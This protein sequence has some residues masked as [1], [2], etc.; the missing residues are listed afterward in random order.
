MTFSKIRGGRATT[1]ETWDGVRSGAGDGRPFRLIFLSLCLVM[2]IGIAAGPAFAATY[3]VNNSGSPVCH[4][5][6]TAGSQTNPFCTPDYG[7]TRIASGDTLYVRS[8]TYNIAN[9]FWGITGPSGTASA[10][11]HISVYPGDTVTLVGQGVDTGRIK[12]SNVS[13][14]TFDGFKVTN[15]NQGLFAETIN[16]VTISF[17]E[18]YNVGQEAIHI[19]FNSSFVT[20]DSCTVHDT[21]KYAY[22][23][24]GMY[25][26]S[27]TSESTVDNTNNVTVKNSRIYNT[28][29]EAIELK[30]GTHDCVVDGNN[31]SA[32]NLN[33]VTPGYGGA[34]IEV[35]EAVAAPQHW[36]SNPNHIIRNN[37]V[38]NT[39]PGGTYQLYNS[40]IRLGTGATAYNNVIYGIQSPGVGILVDNN[41]SDSYTR[42]LYHN[43]IDVTSSRAVALSGGTA[44][45]RNNIGPTSTSNKATSSAYYVNAAGADYHLVAGSAPINA[46]VDLTSVVPTDIE[47]N[48]RS[49]NPPPDLGAYE[50]VGAKPAAPTNVQAI[51]H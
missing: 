18:V 3:Y 41:A 1:V 30:P 5:A 49:L 40:G 2:A 34:A 19:R 16:H 46:G 21:G 51:V 28:N 4:D 32:A 45:V 15:F 22:D 26:G 7:L 14:M 43:T 48:S 17:C 37:F 8:G 47:G 9:G 36:D 23:G 11:T 25:I 6:T 12:F 29:D 39:G 38:H 24:E 44:D 35:N 13:Y 27:S 33:N 20:I 50:F 31:I 10:P 42:N